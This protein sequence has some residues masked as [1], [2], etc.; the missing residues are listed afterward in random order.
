MI[1]CSSGCSQYMYRILSH[2]I[3]ANYGGILQAFAL[4]EA[5]RKLGIACDTIDYTPHGWR[6]WLLKQGPKAKFRYWLTLAGI[7]FCGKKEWI[8]RYLVPRRHTFFK[9]CFMR[10]FHLDWHYS[11][12][13][14]LCKV[15]GFIVGSDQVWRC[16]Y[17]REMGVPMY[18]L[19]FATQEQRRRSIAYAA[20]F[21]ADEWE[22]T[23]EET[24]ECARLIKEFKAVSVREHSGIRLCREV[25][26][27]EAV[28]MP[29]PTLLLEAEDYSRVIRRWWT[30]RQPKPFLAVYLL[31]E[32]AEKC[33]LTH[34]VAGSAKLY[35]QQLT[36]HGDAARAMDRIPLS[37]PQWLRCMRDC[38][39]V[40]TDSFHGCVFA[41]IFNKPFVCLGNEARGSARFDSLLGTFGLQDRLLTA[42]TAEQV[43]ECMRTPIDW[44][45][46]NAI[47]HSE[48]QRAFDFLKQNLE[49]D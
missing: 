32:T 35:P 40:L 19:S 26:G 4:Q 22:G 23:P 46:V 45:R 3:F 5:M 6:D 36:A 16:E 18:F 20:S 10:L 30:R 39:C 24:A 41:I 28:Q 38:E 27:V 25:F 44:E 2:A 9:K 8:P 12:M 48:Q 37:V 42:P 21:G 13:K 43:A 14:E 29:D 7:L 31:D 15:P 33:A 11:Q 49:K 17:V 1:E 47:R 34:A